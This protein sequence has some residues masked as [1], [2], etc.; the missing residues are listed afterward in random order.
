M[1]DPGVTRA[2]IGASL[3]L[4]MVGVLGGVLGWLLRSAAGAI[5]A[6]VAVLFLLPTLL[7]LV[8]LDWVQT[9]VD[10]M[11]SEAGQAIY[12]VDPDNIIVSA[13]EGEA[14]FG[15]WEGFAVLVAWAVGGLALAGWTLMRRDA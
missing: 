1:S 2:V 13:F 6:L 15:P 10:F 8:Q 11:P 12:S 14:R 5:V 3:Y 7:P 9:I 4:A